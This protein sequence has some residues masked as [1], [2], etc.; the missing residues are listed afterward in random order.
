MLTVKM[1][2]YKIK[3][4][5]SVALLWFVALFEPEKKNDMQKTISDNILKYS[6]D[7]IGEVSFS[8][9]SFQ[10]LSTLVKFKIVCSFSVSLLAYI[11][12]KN[13]KTDLLFYQAGLALFPT[14]NHVNTFH[15]LGAVILIF[16]I[17]IHFL[18]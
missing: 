8:R 14:Q 12:L 13:D 9:I 3:I 17:I 15:L 7:L 4:I 10:E 18:Q 5:L 11:V 6:K 2:S 1:H 16:S